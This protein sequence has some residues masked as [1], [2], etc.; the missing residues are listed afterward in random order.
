MAGLGFH[1]WYSDSVSEF[2]LLPPL[3]CWDSAGGCGH[4]RKIHSPSLTWWLHIPLAFLEQ[5][6]MN[7]GKEN[8]EAGKDENKC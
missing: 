6:L 2:Y 7:S 1:G 3:M 8:F 4:V 5:S